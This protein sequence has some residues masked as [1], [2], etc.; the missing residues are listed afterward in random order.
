MKLPVA[1]PEHPG[2]SVQ[3]IMLLMLIAV[4]VV[5]AVL[6]LRGNISQ[7]CDR[8]FFHRHP[9]RHTRLSPGKSGRKSLAALNLCIVRV[10]RPQTG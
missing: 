3:N 10:M 5:S 8:N 2:G 6:D 4:A 9:Q 7:G 1:V